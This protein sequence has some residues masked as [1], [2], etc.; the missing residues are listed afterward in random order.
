LPATE[1][2]GVLSYNNSESNYLQRSKQSAET[3]RVKGMER[4]KETRNK[5]RIS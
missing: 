1:E 5:K 4:L 2:L 3:V